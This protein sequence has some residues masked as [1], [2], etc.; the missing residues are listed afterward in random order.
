MINIYLRWLATEQKA[1]SE[2]ELK[3]Q[4]ESKSKSKSLFSSDNVLK[5]LLLFCFLL[6]MVALKRHLI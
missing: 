5:V 6:F 2:L 1:H 4:L 3:L